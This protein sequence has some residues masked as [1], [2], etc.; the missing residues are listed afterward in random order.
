MLIH[1]YFAEVPSDSKQILSI[2]G[3]SLSLGLVRA[4]VLK[5]HEE[6]AMFQE[7]LLPVIDQVLDCAI[8][9]SVLHG[10]EIFWDVFQYLVVV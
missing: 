1:V 9:P 3:F 5:A 7:F 4:V 2:S 8:C 10:Q 6:V